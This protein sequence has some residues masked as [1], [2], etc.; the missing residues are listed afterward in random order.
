[1]AGR[2]TELV[3]IAC[4]REHW[5]SLINRGTTIVWVFGHIAWVS[6]DRVVDYRGITGLCSMELL[7]YIFFIRHLYAKVQGV[8]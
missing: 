1:M 4:A 7:S 2:Q 3:N 8:L 5:Q 6:M